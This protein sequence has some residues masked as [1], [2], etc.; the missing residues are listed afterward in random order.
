I[1]FTSLFT[2]TSLPLSRKFRGSSSAIC[3]SAFGTFLSLGGA[4][5]LLLAHFSMDDSPLFNLEYYY[6]KP[7]Q[8]AGLVFLICGGIL[9]LVSFVCIIFSVKIL[10]ADISTEL[11][12][13]RFTI[14]K[15]AIKEPVGVYEKSPYQSM[16]PPAYPV[17]ENKYTQMT[18]FSPKSELKLYP[19]VLAMIRW[20]PSK[21]E[22]ATLTERSY[23][24]NNWTTVPQE[25]NL[26]MEFTAKCPVVR[27][28][29]CMID[30]QVLILLVHTILYAPS[31]R[32]QTD[33]VK[34]NPRA[35]SLTGT[36][37]LSNDSVQTSRRAKSLAASS[38]RTENLGHH[39]TVVCQLCNNNMSID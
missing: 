36:R 39:V 35:S 23:N 5:M 15:Q 13:P 21:G 24:C 33:M 19:P 7:I 20:S 34:E 8:L 16:P 22:T 2:F 28:Y 31:L 29:R 4:L 11:G 12:R 18:V 37:K 27:R 14:L 30:H 1:L 6:Q 3:I 32:Q 17:L 10:S 9:V 38:A 26:E 25:L